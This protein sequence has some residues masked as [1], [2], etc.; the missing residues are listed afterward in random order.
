MPKIKKYKRWMKVWND[1]HDI[2]LLSSFN[3][4]RQSSVRLDS[5][6]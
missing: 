6:R 4:S 1:L 5:V 3:I 2:E